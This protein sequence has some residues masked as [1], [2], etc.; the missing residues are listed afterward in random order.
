MAYKYTHFIPQ[1]VAPVGAKKIGVYNS[2]GEKIAD[3][4]L[5]NLKPPTENKLYSFGILS[6]LHLYPI[7]AVAW[8]PETKFDNA[9]TYFE[10]R[11]CAFCVVCGDLTQTGFYLRTDENTAGTEVLD[12]RQMAK[13]KEILDKHTISVYELCG[14]HESYYDVPI[15]NSLG[16]WEK[17]T[18]NSV[19]S[20]TMEQGDD[21]FI[22]VSQSRML[23]VMSD[24]DFTWLGNT[25]EA[26]KDKRCFVF[27]HSHI[28]DNKDGGVEDSGN[29]AFARENSI[30]GYWGAT[31]TANFINLMK[32]YPNTL[33]FH[34]HTHIKFEAQIFDKQ[35]NYS[36]ENGFKSV[37]IPSSG[38]PRELTSTDGTWVTKYSE[39]QGYIVDVYD[40]C[41]V[42]NG[43]DLINN[44]YV[45]LGVYKIN[46]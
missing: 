26:N 19:L 1:N 45:P 32:Q 40:D 29:P 38:T 44:Q 2:K 46:T 42:L 11:G 17:Y 35:A 20:Y 25:L 5:G 28:D 43:M 27:I 18:G 7:A 4:A 41:I 3:I 34:G 13:Y 23:H 22:F 30:F 9:L 24:E 10:N 14:N 21:V 33:L 16:L 36:E 31:K 12:E 37:H 8:T 6:D 39:S 15:T